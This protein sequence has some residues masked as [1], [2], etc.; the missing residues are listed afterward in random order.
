VSSDFTSVSATK[1][2][3]RCCASSDGG[4]SFRYRRAVALMAIPRTCSAFAASC[5][6]FARRREDNGQSCFF[7]E[8]ECMQTGVHV[9]PYSGVHVAGLE[10]R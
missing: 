8:V 2:D 1:M 5:L 6:R 9:G 7:A 3:G 10:R 4:R